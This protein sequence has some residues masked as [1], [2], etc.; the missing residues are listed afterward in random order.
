MNNLMDKIKDSRNRYKMRKFLNTEYLN[1]AN[2]MFLYGHK[3]YIINK[4]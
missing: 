2:Y 4:Q 3:S 1:S